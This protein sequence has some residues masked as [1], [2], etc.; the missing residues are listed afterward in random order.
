[1]TQTGDGFRIAEEDLKLRGPGDFFGERQHGL[2]GLKLTDLGMDTQLLREA[3]ESADALLAR[4]PELK[5]CPA[6]AERVTE[7]FS[8]AG[9]TLN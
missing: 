4:D 3:Q 5:S 9:D 8:Q 1:M 6:T 7:L 2:P